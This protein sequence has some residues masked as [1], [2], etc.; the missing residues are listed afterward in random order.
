VP[1]AL[2]A[3]VMRCVAKEVDARPSAAEIVHALE[4]DVTAVATP[5]VTDAVPAARVATHRRV[6]LALVAGVLALAASAPLV[7]RTRQRRAAT[8]DGPPRKI[9]V[10]PLD[11]VGGDT[12]NAYFAAGLADELTNALAKI[13]GLRVTPPNAA[14]RT[15]GTDLREL[16]RTLGVS[17]LLDGS[18]QRAG[19]R[20]RVRVRLVSGSDGHVLWS[21]EYA[22]TVAD[23]FAVQTDIAD[24]VAA[25]MR[26]TL[27]GATQARVARAFG[28]QNADAYLL[29]LQG[30]HAAAQYTEPELRRGIA[31]YAAAIARDSGFARAW[32]GTADAWASLAGDFLPPRDALPRARDAAWRALALDSTLAEPH[33]ALGNVLLSDW[34]AAGA[35]AAFDR[36]IAGEPG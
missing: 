21:H 20:L 22:R 8:D 27:T 4:G 33:V 18:V 29:Y 1:P 13:E 31:L 11:E 32:A 16:A 35:A 2:A 34:D 15:D 7:E 26:V 30:R 14:A 36:A 9:A 12:A 10:L 23:V 25:G 17:A 5:R 28:T 3:L 24:S 6:Q 19:D